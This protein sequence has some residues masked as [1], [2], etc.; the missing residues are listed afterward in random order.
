MFIL[1][2]IKRITPRPIKDMYW[3]LKKWMYNRKIDSMYRGRDSSHIFS[4]VYQEKQWGSD[5]AGGEYCSGHGSR[6]AV[7]VE[8]FVD[9]VKA[10]ITEMGRRPVVVDLGCGDF[11]VGQQLIGMSSGY[12]ACDVVQDLIEK[13]KATHK[14]PDLEFRVLDIAVDSLPDGEVAILRTVLQHLSNAQVEAFLK[15][16]C[17]SSYEF[18]IVAEYLPQGGF[19]PNVDQPSGPMSRMARGLKSG[20]VLTAEPFNLKPMR[21]W[22][23][24]ESGEDG[25]G[26]LKTIVYQLK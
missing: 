18:L 11:H 13:H 15:N 22:T 5:E 26:T 14:Y 25:E 16:L 7:Y 1:D 2:I 21:E 10:F 23:I 6:N 20:I 24:S 4:G 12:V 3:C 19:E 9:G 17:Q 8:P